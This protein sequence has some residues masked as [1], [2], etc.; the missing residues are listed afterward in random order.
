MTGERRDAAERTPPPDFDSVQLTQMI[1]DLRSTQGTPFHIS[2][3]VSPFLYRRDELLDQYTK[4][5]RKV[6]AGADLA[7]TSGGW[8]VRKFTELK[9]Y[10]DSRGLRIPLLGNVQVLSRR[11]QMVA[12]NAS[13]VR[14]SPALADLL[15][16]E[17]DAPDGGLQA[18]LERAARLLAVLKGLG[19]AGAYIS[20]THAAEHISE[21]LHL[22]GK[23]EADWER[24]AEDVQFGEPD[25][26]YL[27]GPAWS[28][29]SGAGGATTAQY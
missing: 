9:R 25:G 27:E 29:S 28:A 2:V 12:G 14:V 23:F 3:A 4:L 26:F 6:A 16:R 17:S 1:A 10:V 15:R 19:Y 22:A 21:V 8:D 7:I 24:C 5:E 20:G 11:E 13:A 18:R